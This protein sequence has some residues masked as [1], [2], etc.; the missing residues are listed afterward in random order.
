MTH[1]YSQTAS[2]SNQHPERRHSDDIDRMRRAI[3][4]ENATE[5]HEDFGPRDPQEP[6]GANLGAPPNNPRPPLQKPSD[7]DSRNQ[8]EEDELLDVLKAETGY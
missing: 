4:D 8:N 2:K 5:E 6:V 3:R 7:E 1:P